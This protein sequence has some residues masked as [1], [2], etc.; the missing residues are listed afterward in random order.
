MDKKHSRVKFSCYMTNI[1][2]AVVGNLSPILFLTFHSMYGISYSLLGTLVLVNCCTQL[3]VDVIFSFFSHKFNIPLTVKCTPI[4]GVIGML[5]FAVSPLI[6]PNA[7]YLGLVLGTIIFASSSGLAEVLMSP[8]IA[9]LPSENPD[10]EMSKL[11]AVYAWGAVGVVIVATLFLLIFGTENWQWLAGGFAIVP[12]IAAIAFSR[13][14]IP[15]MQTPEKMS[16]ALGFFKNGGLWLCVMAIFLGGASEV[17]MAQW[18]SVYIEKALDIPKVWGDICGVAFFGLMLAVGRTAYA[19]FGKNIGR[20]LFLGAIGA[21]ACYLLAVFIGVPVVGLIAC[22][23]TGIC[24]SMM[25]PGSLVV[26][27][28]RFPNGGVLVYAMMAAGGDLGASVAPQL[29]GVV[30]D[31]V[32]QS[33][34]FITLATSLGI[35]SEQLGLK[36]GLLVG[37]IFPIMA[38]IVFFV[39]RRLRTKKQIWAGQVLAENM[40]GGVKYD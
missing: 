18:S 23:L 39:I 36:A 38:I 26:A 9:A 2:M 11:H 22:A 25:W 32:S 20:V 16:G 6:F 21:S 13:A 28:D 12:L 7:V 14:E 10:R 15:Q 24:V 5:F 17:T 31:S 1:T 27:S 30:A 35:T 37:A 3:G 19:K 34:T 29:V 40:L 8:V 33:E 4:I